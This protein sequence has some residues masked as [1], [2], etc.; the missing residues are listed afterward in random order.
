MTALRSIS[1]P[2]LA[3]SALVLCSCV[4]KD[5]RLDFTWWKDA[6]APVMEDDVVIESGGGYYRSTPA[7]ERVPLASIPREEPEQPAPARPVPPPP[8]EHSTPGHYVVQPGDT[9]SSIARRYRTSVNALVTANK[10]ASANV[11]LRVNQS[12]RIPTGTS[13]VAAA[14]P[15]AT[16]K[17][18]PATPPPV[19]ARPAPAPAGNSSI[20]TVKA[21]DTLYRISRQYGVNPAALM[22]AN[23]LTPTT[24]N[25]IRVG[26]TLRIP[27][28]N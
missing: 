28:T 17:P 14:A 8:A 4:I 11:P 21:G 13:A 5:G 18:R 6:A 9:L 22:R 27:A 20:Y 19:A 15:A 1:L 24:A 7:P 26:S 2:V 16:P 10:M 25:T 3:S 23:G 12:L